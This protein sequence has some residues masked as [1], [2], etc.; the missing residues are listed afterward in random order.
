MI[1]KYKQ[2]T[3]VIV[4]SK[5]VSVDYEEIVDEETWVAEPLARVNLKGKEIDIPDIE[6]MTSIS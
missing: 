1:Q 2:T 6:V 3:K 4:H 5:S